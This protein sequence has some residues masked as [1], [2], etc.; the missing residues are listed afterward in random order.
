[1]ADCEEIRPRLAAFLDGEIEDPGPI[2]QHLSS[3][4]E[5]S[6]LL[7]DHEE[8]SRLASLV[9][10]PS[11]D[12]E[13]WVRVE[14]RLSSF[15]GPRSYAL[16]PAAAIALVAVGLYLF[17]FSGEVQ[18]PVGTLARILGD[19][20]LRTLSV[21]DWVGAPEKS[22]ARLGDTIRTGSGASARVDLASGGHLFLDRNTEVRFPNEDA[23]KLRLQLLSGRTCA[24]N[25]GEFCIEAAG[26]EV[27][28][29]D[30]YY[31]VALEE[32]R[33]VVYV[34]SGRLNWVNY[35]RRKAGWVEPMHMFDVTGG[36]APAALENVEVFQWAELLS[37]RTESGRH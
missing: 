31:V 35:A 15:W 3:C 14:P 19:V 4:S 36:A 7:S 26:I 21:G 11:P 16:V 17:Y 23:P 18:R 1:L 37:D 25:C 32:G 27:K 34:K 24:C 9:P 13:A 2:E 5:C 6:R 30:C 12:P 10:G 29:G 8:V 20:Q 28:G 22:V 33:P